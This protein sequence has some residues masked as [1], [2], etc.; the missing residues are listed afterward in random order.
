MGSNLDFCT[1]LWTKA[2][3]QWGIWHKSSSKTADR[4]HGKNWCQLQ[5][6]GGAAVARYRKP[7]TTP[8]M[9]PILFARRVAICASVRSSSIAKQARK[10]ERRGLPKQIAMKPKRSRLFA[11]VGANRRLDNGCQGDGVC[12]KNNILSLSFKSAI[13]GESPLVGR[14]DGAGI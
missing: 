12:H 3:N 8:Q 5:G 11:R 10:V 13:P 7:T 6:G 9:V 1:T 2:L 4:L 14:P